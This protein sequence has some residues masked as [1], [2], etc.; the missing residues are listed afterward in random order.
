M[1]TCHHSNRVVVCAGWS[2][3]D[4]IKLKRDPNMTEQEAPFLTLGTSFSISFS[5]CRL[6]VT[7]ANCTI[8][9]CS[10]NHLADIVQELGHVSSAVEMQSCGT[11]SSKAHA[12]YRKSN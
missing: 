10:S 3:Y 11:G 6:N 8:A 4:K 2:I 5:V 9:N 7:I 1:V 12:A